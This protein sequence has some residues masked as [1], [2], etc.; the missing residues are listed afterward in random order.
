MDQ[1]AF[2]TKCFEGTAFLT[3]IVFGLKQ[4]GH[5]RSVRLGDGWRADAK[6]SGRGSPLARSWHP[7]HA[8][9]RC[10]LLLDDGGTRPLD[11]SRASA[12]FWALAFALLKAGKSG[13][14]KLLF[15]TVMAPTV[16]TK[17]SSEKHLDH[18]AAVY[19]EVEDLKLSFAEDP[20]AP[21]IDLGDNL[22]GLQRMLKC[23]KVLKRFEL[24]LPGDFEIEPPDFLSY[25][26]VFPGDG[27]WPH[28]T[29]FTL[30]NLAIGTQDLITLTTT[31]MPSL[32]H[33]EFGNINLLDAH[34]EGVI[35]YLRVSDRLSS[36][37][38]KLDSILFHRGESNYLL[39]PRELI[40]GRIRYDSYLRFRRSLHEYVV[41]WRHE[42]TL[43]HPSLMPNQPATLSLHYLRDVYRLCGIDSTG[44]TLEGLAKHM[45]AEVARFN[46]N[47]K[48][49]RKLNVLNPCW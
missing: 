18:G 7:F 17:R 12:D 15:Q 19:C 28:I 27:H 13:I 49:E 37:N 29:T 35:E 5:I 47:E 8:R 24:R 6:L 20:K 48:T 32:R 39:E 34:W 14:R 40:N 38:L 26:R 25:A 30:Q 36:F 11:S 23:M 21:M 41:N 4:L 46:G 44:D 2:E 31:K 10:W 9:P 43:R 42:P 16:F 45:A 1:A 22:H 3:C 33:L